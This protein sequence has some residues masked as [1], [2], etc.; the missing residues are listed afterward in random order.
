M[1]FYTIKALLIL[2]ETDS[3][4]DQ[5]TILRRE[6]DDLIRNTAS[7]KKYSK[8]YVEQ[9]KTGQAPSGNYLRVMERIVVTMDKKAQE[10]EKA[11]FPMHKECAYMFER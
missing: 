7:F 11:E 3:L 10:K 5:I 6:R 4:N 1:I 8:A 9:L 2:S